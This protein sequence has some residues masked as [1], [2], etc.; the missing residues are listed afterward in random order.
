MRICCLACQAFAW[1]TKFVVPIK[2]NIGRTQSKKQQLQR[3]TKTTKGKVKIADRKG[4][5]I[6]I[7]FVYAF[8]ETFART[9]NEDIKQPVLL[10]LLLW[11]CTLCCGTTLVCEAGAWHA[12]QRQMEQEPPTDC[13]ALYLF[14][15]SLN[16]FYFLF[17]ETNTLS[18]VNLWRPYHSNFST[19][20]SDLILV[21]TK[22]TEKSRLQNENAN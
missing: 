3:I 8:L 4:F 6:L 20:L 1:Q 18:F 9:S 22:Q 2:S 12:E 13:L 10:G 11:D 5:L 14:S 21:Y 16:Q 7:L 15:L 19:Y 17:N